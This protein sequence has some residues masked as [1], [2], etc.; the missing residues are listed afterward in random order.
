MY[1]PA[2]PQVRNK[3][4]PKNTQTTATTQTVKLTKIIQHRNKMPGGQPA[5]DRRTCINF[6]L[7]KSTKSDAA[8][9]N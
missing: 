9:R 1:L 8:L 3:L 5:T 2:V 7:V 4:N 6:G